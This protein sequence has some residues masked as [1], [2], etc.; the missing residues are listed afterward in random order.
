MNIRSTRGKL[1]TVAL[2]GLTAGALAA[3]ASPV[4]AAASNGYVSGSGNFADD[5]NDEGTLST[6]SYSNSGAACLWQKVLIAEGYILES[7]ADGYFG[8]E[9]K[10]ATRF[11]QVRWGLADSYASADGKV[12][13]NTFRR[14]QKN[15]TATYI[16]SGDYRALRY[17]GRV[18]T[19]KMTRA[20]TGRYHMYE[21]GTASYTR[22]GCS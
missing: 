10:A 4:T 9:T 14:A 1:I 21:D 2:A 17:N 20:D 19:F 11:L 7:G 6:T 5:W 8:A 18:S 16:G 3:G 13:P 15:V 12:G 22:N